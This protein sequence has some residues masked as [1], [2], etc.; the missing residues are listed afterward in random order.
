MRL[1]PSKSCSTHKI[2]GL[3]QNI[4]RYLS[5]VCLLSPT[6]LPLPYLLENLVDS[7]IPPCHAYAGCA[8]SD[9]PARKRWVRGVSDIDVIKP[10]SALRGQFGK[11]PPDPRVT[12]ISSDLS[13]ICPCQ[14]FCNCVGS[15]RDSPNLQGAKVLLENH[16]GCSHPIEEHDK[17]IQKALST[18]VFSTHPTSSN[19]H[20]CLSLLAPGKT[21]AGNVETFEQDPNHHLD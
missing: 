4:A 19:C 11:S 5:F 17:K 18:M 12:S 16:A 8:S 10:A 1:W 2:L 21:K 13:V 6:D 20:P 9:L 3:P 15:E 7:T 14:V